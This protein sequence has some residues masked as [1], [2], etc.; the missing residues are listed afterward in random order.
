[1]RTLLVTGASS[2]VGMELIRYAIQRYDYIWAHYH[3]MNDKLMEIYQKY[4]EKTGLVQA[5]FLKEADVE[6]L[7]QEIISKQI[8]PTHIVHLP[9]E[10]YSLFHFQSTEWDVY[11]KNISISI[12]SIVMILKE[13][14][15][16]IVKSGDGRIVF[17]LSECTSDLPPAYTAHYTMIKYALMGLV[18]EL[19]VEYE[20]K[21]VM[22]NGI[23][24]GMMETKF[25]DN[26]SRLVIEKNAKENPSGKNIRVNELMAVFEML[27]FG[28]CRISGQNIVVKSM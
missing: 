23:S 21:N 18:K 25:L 10:K 2:D 3:Q 26:V 13:F 14:M 17:M 15:P 6:K 1:M 9:A 22:I 12:R 4:P 8:I 27:L 11:E 24:P 20:K 5:D 19:A 28:N 7:I 16:K